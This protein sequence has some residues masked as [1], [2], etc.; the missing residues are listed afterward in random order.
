MENFRKGEEEEKG[1]LGIQN[2]V[3][4]KKKILEFHRRYIQ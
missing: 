4:R 2:G 1:D 3:L